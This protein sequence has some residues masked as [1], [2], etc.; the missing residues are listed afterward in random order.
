MN[1]RCVK[2][3]KG[4]THCVNGLHVGMQIICFTHR[5]VLTIDESLF[6]AVLRTKHFTSV[7]TFSRLLKFFDF[8][9]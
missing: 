2:L 7:P 3:S 9:L 8:S 5:T 6:S 4:V 1:E